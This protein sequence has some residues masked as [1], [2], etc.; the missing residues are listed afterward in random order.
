M[1]NSEFLD[2]NDII[3]HENENLSLTDF[4]LIEVLSNTKTPDSSIVYDL[5]VEG[6]RN[7]QLSDLGIVH[8]GGKRKGAGTVALP[9]WH[10]DVLDFFEMQLEHGD[11][12][13]KSYDVF[14]Q[15]VMHDA[16]MI[17]DLEQRPWVTFCPFEVKNVLGIDVRGL[18]GDAF[19]DA[20][21]K[22]EKAFDAGK[23]KVATKYDNARDLMKKAMVPM[24]ETGMPYV[25]FIDTINKLN[26][27]RDDPET[28]GILN[29]N[30]CV[31]SYSNTKPDVYAHVCN[32]CSINLSNIKDMEELARVSRQAC[33]MLE[34]GIEL[35]N[36][37]TEITKR[38]NDRFRTI[39]I[40]I[41]GLH[42]YL[43][44]RNLSY[45]NLDVI[46]EISEC[47]EY[48]AVLESIELAKQYGAFPAFEFSQWKSGEM[49]KR[50]KELGCGKY[51]WDAAQALIDQY[52]IRHSQLTSPAPTTTTSLVQDCSS[53]FLPVFDSFFIE[54]NNNGKMVTAAKFLAKHPLGYAKTL[55]KFDAKEIIDIAAKLQHHIDTGISMELMFD[56]NKP[57]F[58]AKTVWEAIH[59]AH[60]K[61]IKAIYYIRHI[62]KNSL[63]A[64][65]EAACE[66]CAS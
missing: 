7:Y 49:T 17:R 59:Y 62:K 64:K 12:R 55:P 42:D 22:I 57:D 27:N 29:V 20:Y 66:S 38:H 26:P 44:K 23:L 2:F 65:E 34:Y 31:E 35:T 1:K 37:P 36:D 53:S 24:F 10:N 9:I 19:E 14:P 54:E 56:H 3:S 58:T 18:Y 33:R 25:A 41:M 8:N 40:G 16:F 47:I 30:L 5:V 28:Y 4:D 51:D 13:L 45:K 21:Q 60:Q 61:G 32:L 63:A 46:G 48:N 43:A 52:G 50:F 39:G 11:L 15:L 6:N